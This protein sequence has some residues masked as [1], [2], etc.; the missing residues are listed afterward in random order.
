[1][2]SEEFKCPD[3]GGMTC[4]DTVTMSLW[5]EERPIIIENVPAR[6]CRECSEQFYD[7]DTRLQIEKLRSDGF[8]KESADRI[9][10]T[11]VFVLP[12]RVSPESA[13]IKDEQSE[14]HDP[15]KMIG[16]Y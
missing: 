16:M 4:E 5:D 2:E 14:W 8:P 9:V 12:D 1:M 10:E 3:C 15:A 6:V 13:A 7:Q 11:P